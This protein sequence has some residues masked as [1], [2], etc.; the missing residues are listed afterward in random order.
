MRL[1][2]TF[3]AS[4]AAASLAAGVQALW[5]SFGTACTT[6]DGC[7]P[8]SVLTALRQPGYPKN[9]LFVVVGLSLTGALV[10]WWSRRHRWGLIAWGAALCGFFVLS[11]GL[12]LYW[13]PSAGLCLA[14]G[15]LP[16]PAP[17]KKQ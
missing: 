3:L 4:S 7:H 12:D 11:F 15:L 1:R 9:I 5:G 6:L 17:G 16:T 8:V 10:P 2:E 14:A 13:L